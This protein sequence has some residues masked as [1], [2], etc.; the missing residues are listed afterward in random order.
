MRE[1]DPIYA[2]KSGKHRVIGP[3][4]FAIDGKEETAW[5]TDADPGRRNVPHQAVF[6][7]DKPLPDGAKLTFMLKQD[8]GGWNS[9]DNQNHNLGRFRLSFTTR[10]DAV[11]DPVPAAVREI[12]AV[13]RDQRTAEQQ[14]AVFSYWRTTVARMVRRQQADR[15][16][17]VDTS[18]GFYRSSCC[19]PARQAARYPHSQTRQFSR[20]DRAGRSGRARVL[21]S[22]A[23]RRAA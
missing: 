9:D 18:R 6:T 20:A 1:L 15:R 21:E 7:L 8:H 13:P 11:A 23:R 12:L 3:V 10:P 19:M 17:L 2:D 5:A 16:H 22:A 4:S 14:A